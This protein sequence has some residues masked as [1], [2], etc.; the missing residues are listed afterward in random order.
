MTDKKPEEL[1]EDEL[2]DVTGGHANI[3]V[4]FVKPRLTKETGIR[5]DKSGIRAGGGSK[6]R[7]S[8]KWI[9]DGG[10]TKI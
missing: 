3:E 6:L 8:D 4:G 2:G 5:S 1:S 10:D 9:E 7:P